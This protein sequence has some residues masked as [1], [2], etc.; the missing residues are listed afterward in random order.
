LTSSS[1]KRYTATR[2]IQIVLNMGASD[3]KSVPGTITSVSSIVSLSI[4]SVAISGAR[5]QM[6]DNI[7]TCNP[8]T[9][10]E[11]TP[12]FI[13]SII[14]N[15]II[16]ICVFII[17][18][19]IYALWKRLRHKIRH[20]F[21]EIVIN[22]QSITFTST[23][24]I[25]LLDPTLNRCLAL[26]SPMSLTVMIVILFFIIITLYILLFMRDRNETFELNN[27]TGIL[28]YL[29]RPEGEWIDTS[30]N[31]R[32]RL[33]FPL[34][35]G[36]T[37]RFQ[38]FIIIDIAIVVILS[39]VSLFKCDVQMILMI[40]ILSIYTI[41]VI[42]YRPFQE[43]LMKIATPIISGIQ[44]IVLILAVSELYQNTMEKLRIL[45]SVISLF[46]NVIMGIA[47]I[48]KIIRYVFYHNDKNEITE[49]KTDKIN[50]GNWEE[51][52][53]TKNDIDEEMLRDI[54]ALNTVPSIV[55]PDTF[56]TA[57]VPSPPNERSTSVGFERVQNTDKEDIWKSIDEA[58]YHLDDEFATGNDT[59]NQ[60]GRAVGASHNE[61]IDRRRKE[62][63]S[64][65][66]E[67]L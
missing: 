10:T 5:S 63:S 1:T 37:N 21:T 64:L 66:S 61:D 9:K 3:S 12:S 51:H 17:S 36:Y 32:F 28:L 54:L 15:P 49:D 6:I 2:T 19:S 53:L 67:K 11:D 57:T 56:D 33:A 44:V 50:A 8:L 20:T 26:A 58:L 40:V 65:L 18:N 25:V 23:I 59:D 60:Y 34:F 45:L 7:L 24:F 42:Y 46:V 62:L 38:N 31:T 47:F 22:S 41:I 35:E 55:I 52:L 30:S 4:P 48:L 29:I 16:I 39:F 27:D 13:D 43:R 14:E